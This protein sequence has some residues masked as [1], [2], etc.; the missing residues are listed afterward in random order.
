MLKAKRDLTASEVQAIIK[1]AFSVARGRGSQ[2]IKGLTEDEMLA[3]GQV[4]C[5]LTLQCDR[6]VLQRHILHYDNW[7]YRCPEAPP[8]DF[9][10]QMLGVL[11]MGL[12]RRSQAKGQLANLV[13]FGTPGQHLSSGAAFV[14][15]MQQLARLIVELESRAAAAIDTAAS[16]GPDATFTLRAVFGAS[17]AWTSIEVGRA[18]GDDDVVKARKVLHAHEYDWTSTRPARPVFVFDDAAPNSEGPTRHANVQ[19]N[20]F[21]DQHK[22]PVP[23]FASF[24]S[25]TAAILTFMQLCHDMLIQPRTPKEVDRWAMVVYFCKLCFMTKASSLATV[26]ATRPRPTEVDLPDVDDEVASCARRHATDEK[27]RRAFPTFESSSSAEQQRR[28]RKRPRGGEEESL[29]GPSDVRAYEVE[30]LSRPA[31]GSRAGPG[32][33]VFYSWRIARKGSK[34]EAEANMECLR[35]AIWHYEGASNDHTQRVIEIFDCGRGFDLYDLLRGWPAIYE[36][37]GEA[38]AT[39]LQD[40]REK[41]LEARECLQE[42]VKEIVKGLQEAAEE[43]EDDD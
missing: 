10:A 26:L 6:L 34:A 39:E 9:L 1:L 32:D 42:W 7:K 41:T 8:C 24:V 38:R 27:H 25:P 14:P 23:S 36:T 3:K 2:T 35:S 37:I 12:L 30:R 28:K 11:P 5:P 31:P 21:L 43:E 17:T 22:P 16:A 15:T 40:L 19:Q 33:E 18:A 29:P 13:P 20:R 4:V